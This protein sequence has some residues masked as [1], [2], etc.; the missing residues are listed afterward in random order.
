MYFINRLS[1]YVYKC[2]IIINRELRSNPAYTPHFGFEELL[3]ADD[4]LIVHV[5]DHVV[6][7]YMHAISSAGAAYGLSFNWSK[8][9]S[10]SVRHD[11]Q[12]LTPSGDP[13]P[14]K[15]R[16]KYLGSIL[17]NDG[18]IGVELNYR[19]GAARAEFQT[20]CKVWSHAAINK[21]RKL[22]VFYACVIGEL[23]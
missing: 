8:L 7:Q 14:N 18:R 11:V 22:D 12:L 13:I 21:K 3:Y 16:I 6:E 1:L 20:L 15:D 10:M 23:M 17:S 19:L 5:D 2:I 4:T 9:E